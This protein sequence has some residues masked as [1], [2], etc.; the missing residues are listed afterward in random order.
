M[1]K[2]T[3]QYF[4]FIIGILSTATSLWAQVWKTTHK[5]LRPHTRSPYISQFRSFLVFCDNPEFSSV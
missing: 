1:G 5:G 4:L 3:I 2:C